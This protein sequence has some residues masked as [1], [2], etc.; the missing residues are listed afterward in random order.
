MDKRGDMTKF[1]T[2][3]SG[4]GGVGKSVSTLNLA[5]AF[6]FFGKDCIVVDANLTTPNIGLHLGVPVVPINLHHVLNGKKHI[7]EAIY[8]H[9]SGIKIVPAGLA[10]DDL[11][12]VNAD[13]LKRKL[14]DLRGLTDFVIISI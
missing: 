13:N 10:L 12:N 4:K 5:A 6:N 1:I 2:C 3:V 7:A 11:R 14:A 8:L 9:P